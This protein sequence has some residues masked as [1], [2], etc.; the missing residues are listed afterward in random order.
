MKKKEKI[1]PES[2]SSKDY[3]Q[4]SSRDEEQRHFAPPDVVPVSERMGVAFEGR[5]KKQGGCEA[6]LQSIPRQ[7]TVMVGNPF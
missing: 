5:S 2:D 6:G 3:R 1:H 4:Q 7:R